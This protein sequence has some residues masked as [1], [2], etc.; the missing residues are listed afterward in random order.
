[1]PSI[2]LDYPTSSGIGIICYP[3]IECWVK[4][5]LVNNVP[6]NIH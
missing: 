1:M 4:S 6:G 2:Y 5:Y 3:G